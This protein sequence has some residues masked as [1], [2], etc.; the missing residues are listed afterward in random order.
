[1]KTPLSKKSSINEIKAR[2]DADVERFSNLE[3]GQTATI[4][5]PLAMELITEAAIAATPEINRVL[6]IGCGA[7]NNTLRL[8]KSYGKSFACDLCDFS[9]PML[10]RARQRVLEATSGEVRLL[11]G[12]FRSLPLEDLVTQESPEILAMMWKRYGAYLEFLGGIDYQQRVF[13]YIDKEDSPRPLTFQL[14]LLRR[15]GFTSVEVLH[16]NS[17]FAAFGGIKGPRPVQDNLDRP[18]T[19]G[20]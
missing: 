13:D 19:A 7:G 3:T 12:D 5:A 8:A 20:R 15:V 4:D 14:D 10:E 18:P 9:R 17:C 16:K 2:F 1:M 11:E 6:D